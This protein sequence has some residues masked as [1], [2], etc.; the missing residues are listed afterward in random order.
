M[1]QSSQPLKAPPAIV[2]I[3]G[4]AGD[5]TR[6]K[7]IPALFNLVS[8]E[9]LS[10]QIAMVGIDRV[11]MDSEAYRQ[12]LSQ[13]IKS[14][15]GEGIDLALWDANIGKA[16]YMPGDFRDADS[17]RKLKQ[18]L[19][20]VDEDQ[21][22]PGNYLFYLA[23]PPSFFDVI[24]TELGNA[25]LSEEHGEQWRRIII[26]K[27]FGRDLETARDLNK[28][29]HQSFDEHQIYRID[30]YLGKETVQNIMAYRFG[31]GT[32]EPIWNHRYIDH[33]QITVAESLGI[34]DRA[35]YYEEAGALRDM[36][37]N[38]LLA[39]LSVVAMEPPNSFQADAIRDEQIKVL[40]AIQPFDSEQVLR[41]TVRGQYGEGVLPGGD[42]VHGYREEPGI[43]EDSHTETFVAMKLMIDSWRWAGVP[44]YLRTGKRMPGRYSEIVIQYKH[45][46]N[47]MF[48][49]ALEQRKDIGPNQLVLRIQ[50]NEGIS[51]AFNA[52]VPGTV[53]NVSQV[54]MNFDYNDYF[55]KST[56]ASG[57]ETLIYD[58]LCGDAT[59]FKR[60]DHIEVCWELMQ[61]ILDVWRAL[62]PRGFPNYPASSCGP[63]EADELLTR[64]GY[65]WKKVQ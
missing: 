26:E 12:S 8:Q 58:C 48:H 62:P 61:P 57:Y 3:F 41:D 34:E 24:S 55:D 56:K 15:V 65:K 22:T 10:T 14:F 63:K 30:H 64:D 6:R 28:I 4:A 44:F 29:L 46:P 36:I 47:M 38:H 25:G 45:A 23:T 2:V 13:E 37:T 31:N 35:S 53:F 50:P 20:N 27:P 19:L 33:V 54:C 17:Y 51:M 52:K 49:G 32:V 9:L 42:H 7:L 1:S 18:F 60:A 11:D 40:K 59:L 39:V 16:Y 43:A 5:L 21:G